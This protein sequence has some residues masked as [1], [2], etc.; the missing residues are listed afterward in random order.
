M[1]NLTALKKYIVLIL[2]LLLSADSVLATTLGGLNEPAFGEEFNNVTKLLLKRQDVQAEAAIESLIPK[3]DWGFEEAYCGVPE[4]QAFQKTFTNFLKTWESACKKSGNPAEMERVYDVCIKVGKT[5]GKEHSTEFE[6]LCLLSAAKS[7]ELKHYDK[8]VRLCRMLLEVPD[9]RRVDRCRRVEELANKL[10][11]GE[12]TKC[13]TALYMLLG[14]DS[15]FAGELVRNHSE[16]LR[17]VKARPSKEGAEVVVKNATEIISNSLKDPR[18]KKFL[19]EFVGQSISSRQYEAAAI[20]FST[21]ASRK[22]S[23]KFQAKSSKIHYVAVNPD[24]ACLSSLITQVGF[25]NNP[26]AALPMCKLQI[27]LA[28]KSHA[29]DSEMVSIHSVH[30][31]ILKNCNLMKEEAAAAAQVLKYSSR[32]AK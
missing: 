31:V 22:M 5:L 8:A 24:L 12:T 2:F 16:L 32:I 17:S 11:V 29:S 25:G 14:K 9:K 21:W 6:N 4:K 30:R 27:E 15:A 13:A 7:T 20:V 10:N 26:R 1:P 19:N 28:E 3:Y 18:T 23:E